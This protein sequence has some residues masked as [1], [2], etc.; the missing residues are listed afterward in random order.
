MGSVELLVAL[1][2]EFERRLPDTL[3]ID[4]PSIESLARRLAEPHA[5][6]GQ[7]RADAYARMR[8]DAQLPEWIRPLAPVR[9][10]DPSAGV[11]LTGATGFLGAKTRARLTARRWHSTGRRR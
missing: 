2:A 3:V 5:T 8:A 6:A 9:V 10:G 1:S 4:C 7:D 11:L